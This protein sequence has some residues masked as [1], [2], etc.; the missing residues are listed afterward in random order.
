MRRSRAALH[1]GYNPPP[2]SSPQLSDAPIVEMGQVIEPG[3][4]A[5]V[6]GS[7]EFGY[8]GDEGPALEAKL[9]R[10]WRVKGCR[11]IIFRLVM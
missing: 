3:H 11:A 10:L 8:G 7:G 9:F 2:D 1:R 4:I 6:A 5:T